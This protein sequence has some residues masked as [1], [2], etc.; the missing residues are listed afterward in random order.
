MIKWAYELTAVS[1]LS[2]LALFVIPD[3][4][5]SI[6]R[7]V[8]LV[9]A[10]TVLIVIVSPAS[11][12]IKN[13]S[14]LSFSLGAAP[15]TEESAKAEDVREDLVRAVF[16]GNASSQ[17]ASAVRSA[18]GCG[19]IAVKVEISEDESISAY[20]SYEPEGAFSPFPADFPFEKVKDRLDSIYAGEIAFFFKEPEDGEKS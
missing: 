12:L 6:K 4:C 11:D 8:R 10:L 7:G 15:E 1:L 9:G 14:S 17:I 20:V 2:S 18:S 5:E 13:I 3:R 19:D 16:L